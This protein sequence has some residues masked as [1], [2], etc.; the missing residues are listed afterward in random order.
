VAIEV[1][2]PHRT[3]KDELV[4]AT[5]RRHEAAVQQQRDAQRIAD[6]AANDRARA[7]LDRDGGDHHGG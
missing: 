6:Q 5:Q 4:R 3:M 2:D 7:Q 1:P